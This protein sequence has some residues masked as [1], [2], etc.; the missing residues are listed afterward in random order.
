MPIECVQLPSSAL[1]KY[2]WNILYPYTYFFRTRP[3]DEA[4]A[5][6]M[7]VNIA[8]GQG[9]RVE[10]LIRPEEDVTGDDFVVIELSTSK[11]VTFRPS[12]GTEADVPK[13]PDPSECEQTPLEDHSDPAGLAEPQSIQ[14]LCRRAGLG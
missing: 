1:M 7:L 9:A 6:A 11:P 8:A 4:A 3:S 5:R 13:A 12:E 14:E 2:G 10:W